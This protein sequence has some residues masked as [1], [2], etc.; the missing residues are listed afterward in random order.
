MN[1]DANVEQMKS[2]IAQGKSIATGVALANWS[3]IVRT[4]E[5]KRTTVKG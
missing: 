4:G 2:V 3:E 5:Y 1:G